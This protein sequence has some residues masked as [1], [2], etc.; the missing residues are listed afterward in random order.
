MAGG[1]LEW[2]SKRHSTSTA[3]K[4]NLRNTVSFGASA[5][6]R[7]S[8]LKAS[9]GPKVYDRAQRS[10][11]GFDKTPTARELSATAKIWYMA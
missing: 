4:P 6:I 5:Q 10:R 2:P 9:V 7:L 8:H 3:G 1:E 11:G